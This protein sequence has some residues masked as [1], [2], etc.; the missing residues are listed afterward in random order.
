MTAARRRSLPKSAFGLPESRRYP[1]DTPGR[2]V[3]AK[4]RATQ[5]LERGN[6]SHAEAREI[7]ARANRKLGRRSKRR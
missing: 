1:L 7:H 4:A 2:A 3:N 6:L 5:Q